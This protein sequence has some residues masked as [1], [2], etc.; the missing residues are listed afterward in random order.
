MTPRLHTPA[1]SDIRDDDEDDEAAT[2]TSS[3][4]M[5]STAFGDADANGHGFTES[6]RYIHSASHMKYNHPAQ[7][8][9]HFVWHN[10]T[11]T[12]LATSQLGITEVSG[13][14]PDKL[15]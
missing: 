7:S 11:T 2:A 5:Q 8:G 1:V 13:R 10:D 12:A 6:Y 15:A 3:R 4:H 14:H 9:Q